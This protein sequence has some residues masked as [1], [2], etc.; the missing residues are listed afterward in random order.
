MSL[1]RLAQKSHRSLRFWST[2]DR[3]PTAGAGRPRGKTRKTGIL[4]PP[5]SPVT[6]VT[7]VP[8]SPP[9]LFLPPLFSGIFFNTCAKGAPKT[10]TSH[11]RWVSDRLSRSR[12]ARV[13]K[14][15]RN[16]DGKRFTR[17][18]F[19]LGFATL[20]SARDVVRGFCATFATKSGKENGRL[21]RP[22]GKTRKT[23]KT[24]KTGRTRKIGRTGTPVSP[25]SPVPPAPP[26]FT[27]IFFDTCA[28]GTPRLVRK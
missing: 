4:I 9:P 3:R 21:G 24:G 13:A 12:L 23:G 20:D 8:T 27:G 14:P 6:L 10:R 5:V 15:L 26:L 11:R 16:K 22:R 25:V 1:S 17:V 2:D 19:V 7:P 18:A 28:T